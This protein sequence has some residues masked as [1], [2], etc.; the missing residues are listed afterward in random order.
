MLPSEMHP[1]EPH[2]FLTIPFYSVLLNLQ[3]FSVC[4]YS[5]TSAVVLLILRFDKQRLLDMTYWLMQRVKPW[6]S[7]PF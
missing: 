2:G 6:K 3:Y 7:Y 1:S 5:D 4:V